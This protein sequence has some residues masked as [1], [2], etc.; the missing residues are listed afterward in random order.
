[1]N[2][3]VLSLVATLIVAARAFA[4][5][6]PSEWV[7]VDCGPDCTAAVPV[8]VDTLDLVDTSDFE[9]PVPIESAPQIPFK[10][11]MFTFVR[12]VYSNRPGDG[13]LATSLRWATDYPDA[14]R[15]FSEQVENLTGL[16]T[17]YPDGLQLRLTDPSLL[18]Y[19]FIYIVEGSWMQ[20]S[21]EEVSA[22]R[23]YLLGGGF[24][25]VDDVHG[26]DEWESLVAE[27]RRVFPDREPVQLLPGEHDI[28]STFY[29]IS[30]KPQIPAMRYVLLGRAPEASFWGLMDD[31]GRLMAILC[32]N[33]D[34]GDAWEHLDDDR[35]P[36]ELALGQAIP[37]GVNIVVYALTH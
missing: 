28:F 27:L 16:T 8:F 11:S 33:T 13:P 36:E 1:M 20:L 25:M 10:S 37:M 35:Y 34:F 31:S 5:D 15:V 24:L 2:S 3:R 19:P 21:D 12:V 29:E 14:D 26:E 32:H 23:N 22:L 17:N 4:Q 30:E 18:Q 7:I 6:P 9:M